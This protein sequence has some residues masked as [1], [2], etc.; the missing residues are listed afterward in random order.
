MS[1][2]DLFSYVNSRKFHGKD[3]IPGAESQL[4]WIVFQILQALKYLHGHNIVHRDL[5]LENILISEE[6]PYVKIVVTD[7]GMAKHVEFAP[8]RKD[9]VAGDLPMRMHSFCGTM[10]YQAPE[11]LSLRPNSKALKIFDSCGYGPE[12]DLWYEARSCGQCS[13]TT[14]GVLVV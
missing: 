8:E 4:A 14:I 3:R 12:V 1:G 5:K 11:I 6:V 2:G 9:I 10:T 13:L 7:F